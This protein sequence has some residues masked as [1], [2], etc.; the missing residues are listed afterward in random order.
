MDRAVYEVSQ[1]DNNR[2]HSYYRFLSE[3]WDIALYT[4]ISKAF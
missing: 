1:L 4:P 3:S 2:I